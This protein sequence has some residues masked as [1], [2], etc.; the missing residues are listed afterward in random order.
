MLKTPALCALLVIYRGCT[1]ERTP[2][3]VAGRALGALLVPREVTPTFEGSKWLDPEHSE[4]RLGE[5]SMGWEL[6]LG[7]GAG[8]TG[9]KEAAK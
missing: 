5:C 6:P 2:W 3:G 4:P 9:V 7:L 1:I 8:G